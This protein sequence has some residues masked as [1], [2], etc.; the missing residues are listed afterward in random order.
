[1]LLEQDHLAHATPDFKRPIHKNDRL[2][3]SASLLKA[4]AHPMRIAIL[5]LLSKH[6][7]LSVTEIYEHIGIEQAVASHHL[8]LMRNK[9]VLNSKREGKNIYY[10]IKN[11]RLGSLIDSFE[12]T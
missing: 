1:M 11:E 10:S 7:S 3:E 9:G 2:E 4:V 12:L 5:N 6:K 8:G